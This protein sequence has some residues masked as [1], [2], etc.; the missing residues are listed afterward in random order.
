MLKA[1]MLAASITFISVLAANAQETP[2]PQPPKQAPVATH[3]A[4]K[5]QRFDVV[6][7]SELPRAAQKHVE[8]IAAQAGEAN[9]QQLR[10]GIDATP[11]AKAALD[12]KGATSAHVV[13]T[14]MV[15]DGTLTLI[16]KKNT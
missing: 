13:G 6:D 1:I 3:E 12:A 5:I 7:V 15:T 4:P 10:T 14:S 8:Q 2:A 16:T 11:E 9:L